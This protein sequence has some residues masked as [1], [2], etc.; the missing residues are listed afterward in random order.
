M[1]THGQI[2]I[3]TQILHT[4]ICK[5]CIRMQ[6]LHTYENL[7]MCTWLKTK[8]YR[9]IHDFSFFSSRLKHRPKEYNKFSAVKIAV[10]YI[11][12]LT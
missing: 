4:C 3:C 5:I 2:C 1:R 9:G 11:A 10:F 6:N 12:V 7:V 8:V